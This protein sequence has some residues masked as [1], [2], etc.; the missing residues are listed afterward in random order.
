MN[1]GSCP[2]GSIYIY[3]ASSNYC[4]STNLPTV[5]GSTIQLDQI[6]AIVIATLAAVSVLF[7]VIGGLRMVLSEGNPEKV[8]TAR[9]TIKFA[10]IGLV[11]AISAEALVSFVLNYIK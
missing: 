4:G 2:Q 5:T 9:S 1:P 10:V 8:S 6:L 3:N 11:V 7:I